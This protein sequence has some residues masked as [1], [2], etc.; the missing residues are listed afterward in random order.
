M[1]TA[2]NIDDLR[3][4]AKRRLPKV[5]FEFIDGG[6]F[7]E[8]TL[9]ANESDFEHWRFR[10]RVL[11]D[12]TTRDTSTTI[13]G[14]P[15]TSPLVLAPT[16]LAGILSRRGELSASRAAAAAG[17]P[18]CLSTMATCSIEQIAEASNVNRWFQLY[19]LRDRGI[20]RSMIERAKATGCKALVLTVDTKVQGPRERD[21]RNGFTVPPKFTAATLL[22]FALHPDWL[23]DVGL[24]PKVTFRNFEGTQVASGDA[25][26]ITQFIAGQYD[27]S[28]SWKDVE[29]FRSVWGGPVALKGVLTSEDAKLAVDHGIDAV[30]VSNHG[31]RQLDGAVSAVQALTEVVDAV[32][33]RAE[34]ILDGGIR[35]GSDVVKALALG[36]RA[37]MI[38]RAWLYGLAA[39]GEAGVARSLEILMKEIDVTMALLGRTSIA[40]LDRSA[41]TTALGSTPRHR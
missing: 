32:A 10:T 30:I 7:D 19:V 24:G 14:T 1:K 5:I 12:I 39:G 13:M 21:M 27:L 20:T 41:L 17:V 9:R 23:F 8:V 15:A 6:A 26:T 37:C 28:V 18:Y 36:A 33:G 4:H 34:V 31:G 16:G 22:D 40:Q 35:R 3:T 25:V 38:G 11:G 29:W 2:L